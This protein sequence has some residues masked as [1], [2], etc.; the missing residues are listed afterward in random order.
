MNFGKKLNGLAKEKNNDIKTIF[1]LYLS[2]FSL[3]F[4]LFITPQARGFD[5]NTFSIIKHK[6]FIK[7][8]SMNLFHKGPATLLNNGNVLVIGGNTK[9]AEIY[10]Y[11]KNKFIF[12]KEKQNY[13]RDFGATA[14]LLNNGNILIAGGGRRELIKIGNYYSTSNEI[15]IVQ[16]SE[17]YNTSKKTFN[18]ISNMCIPRVSHT[19]L[20]ADNGNVFFFGGYDKNRKN[21]LEIE[22]Y[23][24]NANTFKVVAKFPY[25]DYLYQACVKVD[26]KFVI[27]AIPKGFIEKRNKPNKIFIYDYKTNKINEFKEKDCKITGRK[28]YTTNISIDNPFGDGSKNF[29]IF[30]NYNEKNIVQII[31]VQNSKVDYTVNNVDETSAILI[32]GKID[33]GWGGK[34]SN[35]VII[36]NNSNKIGISNSIKLNTKRCQHFS[37]NLKDGKILVIGGYSI[38]QTRRELL[39]SEIYY[40]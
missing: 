13:I 18:E 37:V 25:S 11:K 35:E 23:D 21:V 31:P 4:I 5:M 34:S 27:I 36:Y 20:L 16:N 1:K 29:I 7:G 17:I 26:D 24:T 39:S 3:L 30:V 9:Q 6:I 14:T 28:I 38:P 32:G 19:A 12:I 8:P 2:V 33:D 40:N 15:E 22:E 10:D